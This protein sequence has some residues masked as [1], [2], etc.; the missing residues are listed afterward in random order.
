[1]AFPG[2][3]INGFTN[4]TNA[5]IVFV[6]LKP[7][8]ERRDPSLSAGAIAGALNQKFAAIQDA[9][10]AG[11]PAAAGDGAG[12]DRRLPHADRGPRRPRF[13]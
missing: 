2:L 11:V 4:S 8:E 1:V 13:R 9:Y 5:G 10:I 3:S 6:T 7:F 12:H